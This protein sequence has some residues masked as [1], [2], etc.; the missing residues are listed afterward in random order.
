MIKKIGVIGAGRAGASFVL[1]F[2]TSKIRDAGF[3]LCGATTKTGVHAMEA[4]HYLGVTVHT[5]NQKLASEA[6]ILLIAVP[7]RKILEIAESLRESLGEYDPSVAATPKTFLHVSGA[8]GMDSLRPLVDGGYSCGSLHP[9]QS[10]PT[11]KNRFSGIYMAVDGDAQAVQIGKSLSGLIGATPFHV[12]AEERQLYHAAACFCSNYVVTAV[13]IAEELLARWVGKDGN[14]LSALMPLLMGTADNLTQTRTAREAL[15]GPI[16]R[17][18]TETIR[19]HL[20][21]LP[22]ELKQVYCVLGAETIKIAI[23]NGTIDE[24]IAKTMS[25][26]FK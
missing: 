21:V 16:S 20:Q 26:L 11:P 10:F 4:S 12:P 7:D 22:E 19:G 5:D 8:V 24:E 9:L 2:G 14:A 18:D 25:A 3:H 15:T 13:N 17:G 6:D 23:D 1:A